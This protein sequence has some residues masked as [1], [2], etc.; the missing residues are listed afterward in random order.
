MLI[1]IVLYLFKVRPNSFISIIF[2][3]E[4]IGRQKEKEKYTVAPPSDIKAK[5]ISA[6]QG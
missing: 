3:R 1:K 5:I 4:M 2:Y 6:K